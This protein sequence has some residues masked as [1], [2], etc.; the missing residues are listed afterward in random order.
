ME[1]YP[2]VRVIEPGVLCLAV[3]WKFLI[4]GPGFRP[5]PIRKK[6]PYGR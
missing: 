5:I 6:Q 2:L 4:G 3:G 1:L